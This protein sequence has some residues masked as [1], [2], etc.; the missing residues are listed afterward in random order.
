MERGYQLVKGNSDYSG[1][2]KYPKPR[3][4]I[5]LIFPRREPL[6]P[7]EI[8]TILLLNMS[9]HAEISPETRARLAAQ[10]RTSTI[11][12]IIVAILMTVL[13][14]VILLLITM[15]MQSKEIPQLVSY[16][17]DSSKDKELRPKKVQTQVEKK[18]AAPSSSMSR[19]IA[20]NTTS[21][22]AVPVPEIDIPDVSVEFG[23]GE[24][25]GGGWGDGD[26]F[27]SG[28]GGNFFGQKVA[29]ERIV[30]I[31]DY[32]SSMKSNGREPLMREEMKNS[33]NSL[34]PGTQYQIIFFSGPAWVAGNDVKHSGDRKGATI[35]DG[36]K[37]YE[38]TGKGAGGWEPKGRSQVPE[39]LSTTDKQLQESQKIV[40][41]SKLS[42]GTSW[43]GPLNMALSMDPL[44]Q[45]ILFMTDGVSGN[46]S[47]DIAKKIAAKAK[48]KDITI[49]TVSLMEPKAQE[50]MATMAKRTGG[51]FTIVHQGG[52]REQVKLK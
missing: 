11:T 34:V 16:S 27:G 45:A 22:V 33:L 46:D 7:S 24:G 17:A 39:W 3:L 31:I 8:P 10:K 19:V 1:E 37:K 51:Q 9:L 30:Y 41:D 28:G 23:D 13:V 47:D 42:F 15:A 48:S 50:A 2:L 25:F 5:S 12:S 18:P 35:T 20:A 36:A 52:K 21:P 14:G 29:A 26:G 44:P 49:N 40:K 38:W 6:S 43:E 32:S 4:Q